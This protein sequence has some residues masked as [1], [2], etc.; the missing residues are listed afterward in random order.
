MELSTRLGWGAA[1]A[2]PDP[3]KGNRAARRA[4]ARWA[5]SATAA[6]FQIKSAAS[7]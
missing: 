5:G 6:F 3:N 2:L 1:L 7:E 4:S